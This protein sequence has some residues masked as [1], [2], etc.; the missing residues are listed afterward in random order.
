MGI[1]VSDR[2]VVTC[3]HVVLY[4][5]GKGLRESPDAAVVR[6]C[7]P[8]ADGFP[9]IDGTVDLKRWFPP[10]RSRDGNVSDVAVILL[11]EDA[12]PSVGRANLRKHAKTEPSDIH[13]TA[14]GFRAK[15]L[16]NGSWQSHSRGEI[17]A[18]TII[19]S[20][21][22]GR[23]QFDGLPITGAAVQRGFSGAGIY[24]PRRDA[25]VGM[26][27]E[28]D[29]NKRKKIAQFIDV[30]S[31]LHA[32]GWKILLDKLLF[33]KEPDPGVECIDRGGVIEAKKILGERTNMTSDAR[34]AGKNDPR[35][36]GQSTKSGQKPADIGQRRLAFKILDWGASIAAIATQPGRLT[37]DRL[38]LA[39][40]AVFA[41]LCLGIA[42]S[43]F[44]TESGYKAAI[45]SLCVVLAFVIVLL[46]LPTKAK[47]GGTNKQTKRRS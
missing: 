3:A 42:A 20:L 6:V 16:N 43:A 9:C 13:P 35:S 1:L 4:A 12:P 28:A 21:P 25:I 32:L 46:I 2:E 10:G 47:K 29:K 19:G 45:L 23:G 11:M 17:A 38:R 41:I 15:K 39:V 33:E 18:G 24:D 8:F 30:P 36:V 27:V 14:Y 31:I 22:G 44:F 5:L 7:F 34:L 26:V 40:F 37:Q